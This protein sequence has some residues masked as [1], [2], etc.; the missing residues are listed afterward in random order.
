MF[1]AALAASAIALATALPFAPPAVGAGFAEP[2]LP[3]LVAAL[4][5][6]CVNITTTRYK[7]VKIEPGKAVTAQAAEPDEKRA[8]GSGFIVS[9]NGYVVTNKHVTVNGISYTV[10]LADGRRLPAD[11]ISEAVAYDIAVLKIRSNETWTP[12][13]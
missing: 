12:V 3:N 13:K 6:S 9:P 11:L 8:Y 7:A 10:T 4:L 5:P 1:R 2:E